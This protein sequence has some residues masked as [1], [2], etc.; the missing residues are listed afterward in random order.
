M[1]DAANAAQTLPLPAR[2]RRR[3]RILLIITAIPVLIFLLIGVL[4]DYFGQIERAQPAAAI[5]VLG[6]RVL[7]DGSPG[8][9]LRARTLKAVALYDRG[10]SERFIFTGGIGDHGDAE[11]IVESRLAMAHGVPQRAIFREETSKTTR[12][13]IHNAALICRQQGW[14]EVIVVSD[15]Y[16]LWRARYLF[17]HEGITAYPSPAINCLRNRNKLL[18]IVWTARETLAV[19]HEVA[20]DWKNG[21]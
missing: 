17:A 19:I 21:R 5:V 10:L 18:R 15:P 2:R 1:D 9:S 7:Q 16:H 6:A 14:R 12:Q 20:V 3:W 13:N 8:D 4:L 11:S